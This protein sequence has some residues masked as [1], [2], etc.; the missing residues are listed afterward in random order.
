MNVASATYHGIEAEVGLRGLLG[1]AVSLRGSALAFDAEGAEGHVGKYALRPTTRTTGLTVSAPLWTGANVTLDGAWGR[2]ST[3]EERVQVDARVAQR[4]R[5]VRLVLDL[6]NLTD[7]DWL[8]A[9]ARPVAGRA[10]F[11]GL[12]W[13]GGGEP[14]G[15]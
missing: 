10:A 14:G 12:E 1:A 6:R 9:A 15:G 3:G 4:W 7:A 11:L 8:D 2:R 5:E 13:R